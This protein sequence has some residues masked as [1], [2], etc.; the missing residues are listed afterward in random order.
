MKAKPYLPYGVSLFQSGN[1]WVV[2]AGKKFTGGKTIRRFFG[3]KEKALEHVKELQ[4]KQ[5]GELSAA[6]ELGVTTLDMAEIRVALSRVQSVGSTLL[7]AVDFYLDR[8]PKA[9]S[10]AVG[11]A[12]KALIDLKR[13][14]GSS[15]RHLKDMKEKYAFY[16]DGKETKNLSDFTREDV[17]RIINMK[18][19]RGDKPSASQ[20]AKRRRYLN[21]LFNDACAQKWIRD[22]PLVGI[23]PPRKVAPAK[24]IFTPHQVAA[25]LW[26]T[27]QQAPDMLP[28][29]VLKC[30]SGI[31]NEELFRIPWKAVGSSIIVEAAFSKTGRRRSITIDPI[32][33]AWLS[34]CTRGEDTD[35]VFSSRG[36]RKNRAAAWYAEMGPIAAA[37]GVTPWPQNALRHLFGSY[38]LGLKKDEGLTAYEMGNSVATVRAN[39]VDAV[40]DE[41]VQAFWRLLPA[42]VEALIDKTPLP[43]TNPLAYE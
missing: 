1:R 37:A 18:D 6:K 12:V 20:R 19:G 38:H 11:D 29:L 14:E 39:Y 10:P 26:T 16:F 7:E 43:S 24:I 9:S 32:L 3:A 36:A 31:R 34:A 2:R 27:Q 33:K 13:T 21:I 17:L 22:N 23:K 25:L 30:F 41:A 42:S 40:T 5:A 28:A 35:L 15:A 8:R 4:K